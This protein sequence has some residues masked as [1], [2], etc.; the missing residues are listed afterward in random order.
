MA[1]FEASVVTTLVTAT[2]NAPLVAIRVPATER[3]AIL[4]MGITTTGT[5]AATQLGIVRATTVSGTP[6]ATVLGQNV[7]PGA[8]ASGTL[9]V[10]AW[11]TAPVLG[12]SYLR[13]VSL[14]SAVGAGVIWSWPADRP[15]VVGQG[16]AIAEIVIA[17]LVALAPMTFQLYLI[18]ED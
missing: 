8:P 13:R 16:S 17:N 2:A 9:L 14:P 10:P 6:A 1:R 3:A 12:A 5:A 18:W 7:I 11:T 15:L 4:E